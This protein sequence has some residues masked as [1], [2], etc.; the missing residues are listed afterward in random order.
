MSSATAIGVFGSIARSREE[1]ALAVLEALGDHRAVQIE[2]DAVEA[3]AR[4]R[5][6]D[7]VGDVLVGGVLDRA[8]RRRAGGDRQHDLGPLALGE[9][10]IGAEPRAGAAIGADRRLA[11]ER[12]RPMAEPRQRRRHRR[13]GVG[14]VLHHRDQQAHVRISL[15]PE[16]M[17][18]LDASRNYGYI[19]SHIPRGDST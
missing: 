18:L 13:E 8:A 7:R 1:L 4:H 6:A 9:V 11:V 12:P 2:H 14:L 17:P 19:Y 5:L 15:A 16:L 10:E 3:A